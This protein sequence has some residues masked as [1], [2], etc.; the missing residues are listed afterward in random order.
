LAKCALSF[1]TFDSPDSQFFLFGQ[2]FILKCLQ[3]KDIANWQSKEEDLLNEALFD[4]ALKS[5]T[6]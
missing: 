6:Y 5:E 2:C 3:L 1:S 4:C